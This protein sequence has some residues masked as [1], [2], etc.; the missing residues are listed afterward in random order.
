MKKRGLRYLFLTLGVFVIMLIIGLFY[1]HTITYQ[2]T[3]QAIDSSKKAEVKNGTIIFEGNK[4]QPSMIFYQGALVDPASYSVW[5]Q[6][7]AEA[8]YSVYIV[9]QPLNLAVLGQNKA[10][11]IIQENHLTDYVVGGHSLGGV[12]ASRFAATHITNETLKGVFFLAS[13][14]DEK[15]SLSDFKGQVLSLTGSEDGV[16]N[17]GAYNDAK[18]FLPQ[19]TIF[20]EI[21]GGN[22]AGF[23]SYG[24]Q[25]GDNPP[26][27]NNEEQQDEVAEALIQWLEKL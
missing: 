18:D 15:G 2:P 21:K 20:E 5:A 26:L 7:V 16:L 1:V 9:K 8:G 11:K 23:G 12:M 25:K 3:T 14:P 4:E 19:Q 24:E 13:Y 22:H 6:K 10:E 17:W 27:I